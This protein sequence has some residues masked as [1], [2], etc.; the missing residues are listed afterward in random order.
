MHNNQ[1]YRSGHKSLTWA[2]IGLLIIIIGVS[3]LLG[4]VIWN[5]IWP[6]II[7]IIG[8]LI[9]VGALFDDK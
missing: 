6:I 4:I 5:Y 8:I 2:M 7:I 9:I 1:K 3:T